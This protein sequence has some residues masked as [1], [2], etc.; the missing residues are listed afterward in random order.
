MAPAG[1]RTVATRN[2]AVTRRADGRISDVHDT[3][4][5]MDIHRGL[6]GSRRVSV[7]R[8]D[9]SRLVA[10]RARRGFVERPYQYHGHDF[11]RRSYYYHG[12]RYDRYYNHYY[13]D[14]VYMDVYAPPVY[15]APAF[16][17]WAYNPWA[18]PIA[19]AGWGW[20]GT[21]WFAFYGA[22]FTSW[23]TYPSAA[24]WLAD[25]MLAADLQAV[26]AAQAGGATGVAMPPTLNIC[27]QGG[28]GTMTWDGTRYSG[29]FNNGAVAVISVVSWDANSIVLTRSDP[30]GVSTGNTAT[31]SGRI[32]NSNEIA[33]TVSGVY[34][35]RPWAETWQA[36]SPTPVLAPAVGA[37]A[38]PNT[39]P[40]SLDGATPLS[41]EVKQAIA[42]E[43][44]NQLALENA[45]AA[46]VKAGQD[47][48]GGSSGIARVIQD[49]G[50]GHPHIFVVGDSLDVT[51]ASTQQEC[52]LSEGDA[53]QMV[54]APASDATA[55]DVVVK[56]SKGGVECTANITVALNLSDV[57]EMQNHMREQID[58]GL[59][60]MQ[61]KAG[62][63]GIPRP[64][65]QA[66]APP[67]EP[68]YAAIAPPPGPQDQSDLETQN[69]EATTAE[70]EAQQGAAPSTSNSP[71]SASDAGKVIPSA[72][73]L[74]VAVQ[75]STTSPHVPTAMLQCEG[76]QCTRGGGGAIWL[77][78]GSSGQAMWHYGA[79]AKLTVERFD[80]R[81]IVIHREDPN[82]SYSSPRFADLSKRPDG[83]FFAD[84]YGTISGNRIDGTVIWNGGGKGTWYATLPQELCKPFEQCPLD[85]SQ[86][87]QL[88]EN[89]VRARLYSPAMHCFLIAAAEG[90]ADG[91]S[92]AG[93]M[94]RDGQGVAANEN[95]AFYMLR[96]S[97][98][99][100]N[101]NGEIGLASMYE[102][103]LG[104]A[105]DPAQAASWK[106]RAQT[107]LQQMQAQQA[108][109]EAEA[110]IGG[111][112]FLGIAAALVAEAASGPSDGDMS[113]FQNS[114]FQNYEQRRQRMRDFDYWSNG[115]T[116]MSAPPGYRCQY[117]PC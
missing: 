52:H 95:A 5:G 39:Q 7:E 10:E 41:P 21:P 67:S 34:N 44:R 38:T 76:D 9:G 50:S 51:N 2:G 17:G 60:D 28:C 110:T 16:Y 92:L 31:Y 14:G 8:R 88:G 3:R 22:Y 94:L 97:A 73:V 77:F 81:N 79:I 99:Q 111:I 96:K 100:N 85:A 103:G 61:S 112:I 33:G 102:L 49:V 43:I 83:V 20:T 12:V 108:Q 84:Y 42:Y 36:T 65:V 32:V 117:G 89:A 55:A 56:S 106:N 68:Q 107:Q 116:N 37:A 64:P 90:N 46:Q 19:Y 109:R 62:S 1:S 69:K 113:T 13:Y 74:P 86:M 71:P 82:P 24:F 27:E 87:V 93:L 54:T 29:T 114:T 59:K 75:A 4:R 40:P 72:A 15:F 80:G 101:Y 104:T 18:A 91:Q 66:Q 70:S 57:Q 25:Y 6:D 98:E 11:A 58:A 35:G 53:V 105:K 30:A 47:V 45:E 23:S 78:Q 26:Y 115:G 48:D 63:G